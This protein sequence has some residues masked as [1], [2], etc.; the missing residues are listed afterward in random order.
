MTLSATF[1]FLGSSWIANNR[2]L[3]YIF[4]EPKDIKDGCTIGGDGDYKNYS[5]W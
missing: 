3:L 5:I 2:S 4:D 1:G